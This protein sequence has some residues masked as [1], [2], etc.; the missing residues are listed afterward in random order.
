MNSFP[1]TEAHS[2]DGSLRLVLA[3]GSPRRRELLDRMG[4]VYAV[5]P[6]VVQEWEAIDADPLELVRHNAGIKAEVVSQEHPSALV[7]AADTT[8]ALNGHVLNKPSDLDAARDMLRMLSGRTHTVYTG[9]SLIH[10]E[11]GQRVDFIEASAVTFRLLDD[12]AIEDYISRVHTLD[13]A[14]AYAIQECGERIIEKWSG[15]FD[16]IM[17]L[18]TE[19][20]REVIEQQG[21]WSV[22][23]KRG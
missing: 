6:A 16:N 3:S 13:K 14:G 1:S 5:C 21:W 19:H 11:R 23:Q 2:P 9:V 17:G 15:S 10:A 8:V 18:P 12:A 4:L 22:L 7:L 20:L